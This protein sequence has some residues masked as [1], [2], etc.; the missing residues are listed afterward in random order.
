MFPY[1]VSEL[2]GRPYSGYGRINREEVGS[3]AEG[4]DYYHY[5]I[6]TV[7]FRKLDYEIDAYGVPADVRRRKRFEVTGWRLPQDLGAEA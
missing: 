7:R 1:V 3:F 6:V 4:I 2:S 5:H